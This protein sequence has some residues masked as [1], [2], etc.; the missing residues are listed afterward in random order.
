MDNKTIYLLR[1]SLT[2]SNTKKIYSGRSDE[3]LS[4]KGV[5][6]VKKA[7]FRLQELKIERIFTS[8]ISRAA[9]TAE[10]INQVLNVDI[11]SREEFTEIEMGPWMGLSEQEVSKR[12]PEEW[13]IWNS[14]PF[15]LEIPERETLDQV[16]F[17]ALRGIESILKQSEIQISLVI[18]HVPVIRM[19]LMHFNDIDGDKY[20]GIEVSHKTLFRLEHSPSRQKVERLF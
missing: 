3:S 5:E 7:T 12:H 20:R 18:A 9:E 16:R 13:R 19:I 6:D 14:T 10:L 2:A 17:R 11:E 1:H 4:Q 15:Q 8:P